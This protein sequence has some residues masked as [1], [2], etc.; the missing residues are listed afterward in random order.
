MLKVGYDNFEVTKRPPEVNVCEKK[1]VFNQ[2]LARGQRRLQCRPASAQRCPRRRRWRQH[3]L[4]ITKHTTT[5]Y[6]QG[7]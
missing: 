4:P 2:Q 3:L 6:R 5:D 1:Y 7:R